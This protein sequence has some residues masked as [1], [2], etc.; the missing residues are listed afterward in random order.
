MA[1]TVTTGLGGSMPRHL[2]ETKT[3]LHTKA[4]P[5]MFTTVKSAN[6]LNVPQL[7][8]DEENVVRPYKRARRNKKE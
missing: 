3:Y 7:M 1:K 6:K 2:R 8:V 5:W 4:W